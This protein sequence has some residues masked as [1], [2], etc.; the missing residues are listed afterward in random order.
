MLVACIAG[1]GL[2]ALTGLA[3]AKSFTLGVAKNAKVTNVSGVTKHENIYTDLHGVAVYTLTHDT[4]KHPGCTKANGCFGFW[5]PVT[6]PKN[7]KLTKAAG[8]KGELGT[9][10]R[11]G[12][13]QLT[14]DK[15]PLYTFKFD[16]KRKGVATG[17]GVPSFGG[18]WHVEVDAAGGGTKTT[19]TTTTTTSSTTT[20][21]SCLYPPCY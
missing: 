1:F 12:F 18:V 8:I 5:F 16:D 17:E 6:V 4:I 19:T 10:H 7:A 2:A 3:I 13:F 15:H 20:G 11:N 9:F 14:L 21:T